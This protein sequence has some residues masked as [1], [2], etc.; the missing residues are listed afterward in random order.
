MHHASCTGPYEVAVVQHEEAV[1]LNEGDTC[2]SER[3]LTPFGCGS[4]CQSPFPEGPDPL[5]FASMLPA[6]LAVA[7]P[8][9]SSLAASHLK[10]PFPAICKYR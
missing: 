1:C 9:C 2:I 5:P 10:C 8:G 7:M 6:P 4:V 3:S